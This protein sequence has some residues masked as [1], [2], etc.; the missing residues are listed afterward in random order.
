MLRSYDDWTMHCL[1]FD[2]FEE[3][4][5]ASEHRHRIDRDSQY[6]ASTRAQSR[7]V[8]QNSEHVKIPLVIMAPM[9]EHRRV[10]QMVQ[11]NDLPTTLAGLLNVHRQAEWGGVNIIHQVPNSRPI[12]SVSES[13]QGPHS[14]LDLGAKWELALGSGCTSRGAVR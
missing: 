2:H 5:F 9:L 12:I 4:G 7:I 3:Q 10:D 13:S 6:S 8:P 1:G 14:R 11:L